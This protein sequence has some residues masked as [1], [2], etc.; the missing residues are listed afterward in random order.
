MEFNSVQLKKV[1]EKSAVIFQ[2]SQCD[3]YNMCFLEY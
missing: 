2:P 1:D 3:E